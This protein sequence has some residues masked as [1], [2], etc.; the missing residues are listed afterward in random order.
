[1]T[2]WDIFWDTVYNASSSCSSSAIQSCS[3][4]ET[5]SCLAGLVAIKVMFVRK[6]RH[7]ATQKIN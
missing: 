7:T 6:R 4:S 1:M 3:G 5:R 2:K